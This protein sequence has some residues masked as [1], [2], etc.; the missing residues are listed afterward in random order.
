MEF[1]M[2]RVVVFTNLTLDGVMQ[3]PGHSD[4]DTR[5]RLKDGGW[6]TPYADEVLG[7][8]AGERMAVVAPCSGDGGLTRTSTPVG[9]IKRTTHSRKC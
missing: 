8:V 7:A 2:S 1:R 6:A 4:E 3:A 5:G 9:P